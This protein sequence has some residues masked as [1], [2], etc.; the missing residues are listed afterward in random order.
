MHPHLN[1]GRFHETACA[2]PWW[3]PDFSHPY[4]SQRGLSFGSADGVRTEPWV[5][6]YG[7]GTAIAY[8]VPA[9]AP[10]RTDSQT[11]PPQDAEDAAVQTSTSSAPGLGSRQLFPLVQASLLASSTKARS[12]VRIGQWAI[13]LAGK[14]AGCHLDR[15]RLRNPAHTLEASDYASNYGSMFR[16]QDTDVCGQ[17]PAPKAIYIMMLT[18]P[19]DTMDREFSGPTFPTAMK[20]PRAT[21]G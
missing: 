1:G 17:W 16:P 20:P 12:S 2:S 5:D 10:G 21:A 4:Y 11:D 15:R 9:T 3:T 8:N 7:H 19:A 14:R 13:C 6:N 18:Q